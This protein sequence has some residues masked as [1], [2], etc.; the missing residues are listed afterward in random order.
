MEDESARLIELAQQEEELQFGAFGNDAALALGLAMVDTARRR[1][2]AVVVD[3][4]RS[5]Q[6]LF[7]H[8]MAGT[9][10]DNT[11]WVRRKVNVV[12]RYAHSSW[13]VGTLYRSRGTSFEE[14]T[15]LDPQEF[16]AA[17]GA[18]PLFVRGV[19]MVGSVAVSGLSQAEDHALV[20]QALRL[21]LAG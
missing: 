19:G 15:R 6:C 18:F 9:A 11:E 1:G 13:Y 2:A 12:R 7:H 14:R 4:Q 8:A 5:G 3:I 17:G 16:A 20:V 21:A 10:I